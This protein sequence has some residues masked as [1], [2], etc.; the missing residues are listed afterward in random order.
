MNLFKS[1]LVFIFACL[2]I[3]TVFAVTVA[4]V[5]LHT[6][7]VDDGTKSYYVTGKDGVNIFVEEKGDPKKTTIIFSSGF[8]T[9]RT[10]WDQQWYDPKFKEKFHLIR[11]DYRGIG[12][13]D[14]PHT[15]PHPFVINSDLFNTKHI[16]YSDNSDTS[17]YTFD[18]QA[19]DLFALINKLSSKYDF[20][21]KK[22]VLVGW[23]M[24]TPITLNFMKNYP[25]IKID[26]FVSVSGL[27]NNTNVFHGVIETLFQDMIDPQ[28]K[29]SRVITGLDGFIRL[30][31][32]KPFS[33][34][35]HSF[36]LGNAVMAPIEYRLYP[37][38]PFSFTEFYSTLTIPTLHI[39]GKNDS[40]V[41]IEHS[42]YFASLGKNAKSIFYKDVGHC[43][44]WENTK[45]F[46][47]DIIKFISKI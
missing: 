44:L 36:F 35:L 43:A 2:T 47:K 38:I 18:S 16:C 5:P 11:Y 14:K 7:P 39:I 40:L 9:S 42:L 46:N 21:K 45:E 25:N 28:E 15:K 37:A 27:V 26:G 22:I 33:N 6:F 4:Q 20:K 10:S 8:L 1:F 41:N 13:S 31:P 23:S 19:D 24:G 17:P 34:E 29:F 12:N 3:S 32:F 30:F